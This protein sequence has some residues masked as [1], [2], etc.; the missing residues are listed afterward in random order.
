MCQSLRSF[1]MLGLNLESGLVLGGRHDS[2]K[3]VAEI[4]IHRDRYMQQSGPWIGSFNNVP[5]ASNLL[6]E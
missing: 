5:I 3:L 4:S 6:D 1:G 2:Y